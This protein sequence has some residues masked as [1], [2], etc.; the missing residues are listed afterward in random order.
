MEKFE[1]REE[2]QGVSRVGELCYDRTTSNEI[3]K[4]VQSTLRGKT[5]K[6][7]QYEILPLTVELN[8]D[9]SLGLIIKKDLVIGVKFDSPCLG[10][11]QSGD[12][13]FT[14]NNEV[15][16]EDPA[17]NKE[18][19]A[20]ANHNGGKYTVSVIRFKRRAPVK[21]IFPKGFEPSED[22]DYQWTVLYL[23]RGMSLGLDVRMI[24]GKVYVAN[25]V[26]DS[27]AGMSLLIGECIVDVEGELITSVS[28]V[29]QLKS[30][31]YSFSVF[32]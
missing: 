25:I 10:I 30:T 19:L 20:K 6:K 22:C 32:D 18:M 23:L 7:S 24:E 4:K 28:Q 3:E 15:F 5:V 16:S 12:I 11:L 31:V 8:K 21:P 26:P 17:K 29:R 2:N 27:I 13:L 1:S 14:F 9:R